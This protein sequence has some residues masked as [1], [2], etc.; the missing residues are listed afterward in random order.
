MGVDYTV[1]LGTDK[2]AYL[3]FFEEYLTLFDDG[4][5]ASMKDRVTKDQDLTEN[6]VK[7]IA[8]KTE[9][10]CGLPAEEAR[11]TAI[12]QILYGLPTGNVSPQG[13]EFLVSI[14]EWARRSRL[15]SRQ[16]SY[17]LRI[18]STVMKMGESRVID[19]AVATLRS[20]EETGTPPPLHSN[21]RCSADVIKEDSTDTENESN[22]GEKGVRTEV[23]DADI[24][25]LDM[26]DAELNQDI[27]IEREQKQKA[28][29]ILG[30]D[31]Y[32]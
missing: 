22:E 23:V 6:M 15:T 20:I 29:D 14:K 19:N 17:L 3:P 7:A 26:F 25:E 4:F 11:K 24:K 18:A 13:V 2:Q 1:G 8:K 32:K 30:P 12:A 10:W 9:E 28:R 21:C 5:I 27:S 31:F 16:V